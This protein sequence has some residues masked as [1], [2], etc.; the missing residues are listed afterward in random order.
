MNGR[1]PAWLAEWLG[2]PVPTNADSATWQLD[3]RW[4][5]APWATL[6]LVLVAIAW[7]VSLYSRESGSAGRVYRAVL[8]SLRLAAIGL[9][10]VMLAQWALAL[11]LTGPPAVALV[12]DHSASMGIADRYDDTAFA[13]RLNERLIANSLTESTRLNIAKLVLTEGNGRLLG[14]LA[15]RY[16]LATYIAAGNV[17]RLPENSNPADLA[18]DVQTLKTDD[19][20]SQATR[21]GDALVR[22]QDDFR[23]APPAAVILLSDGVVTEGVSL[24]DAA[25]GLRSAGIPLVAVGIGS[26]KPPRDIELSDVLVDDVVFV[27]D[28]VSLQV[29]IKASGLEGQPSKVTLK[30]EGESTPLME[31][32]IVLPAG[33]KTLSVHLTE[34]PTKPGDVTYVVEIAPREDESDTK[35]NSQR[36]SV[37]VRDEKIRVLLAQGYPNYE[38]RFLKL[39]LERDP[40]VQ[41]STY[42]QDADPEYAQQDKTALRSFPVNRNDLFAYDVI[43]IGDLDP[44]LLPGSVWQNVRAFVAEKGGGAALIAGP[45]FLPGRYRDNP[46]VSALLPIKLESISQTDERAAEANRGFPVRPTS[47]GLQSPAMQLGDS[48]NETQQIWSTLAPLFWSLPIGELKP[49]AQVLAEGAAKPVICFQYFGAGRVLFH[50]IDSTW[51]WRNGAEE[52]A[53]ARYWV[54]TIRFLAHGKLGKGRGVQLTSDRREYRR[55]DVAK[56]RVR[57]LDTQ[58]APAGD[59]VV[60]VVDAGGQARRRVTLRRNPAVAG[61]FEGSLANMTDGSYE[62]LMVEP[63]LAE[64]PPALRFSV[65]APPGEFARTEM[66]SDALAAAAETTHGRFYTINDVDQ[67]MANLPAGRRVPI[68]NLPPIS[69]WNRWWL[70]AAFLGCITTE[71]ILRKRKGML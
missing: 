34:R 64:K 23:G 57:F 4:S 70:L 14:E 50:A 52:R 36:R 17:K 26:A 55:G 66:D 7:T 30:R 59:E 43:I 71:W 8:V 22:V 10:L 2:V 61:V 18:R 29:Q 65:V 58:L 38:F 39:L 12:I 35:N 62:V 51:R 69:I 33:G 21:V 48:P 46:D 47:L 15:D 54:Q 45:K 60:V 6:L 24:A 68:E 63:Q 3:S 16:R 41:L 42:L 13:S 9:V 40:T 11:W 27:N 67:L 37:S 31:Q 19:P 56:L 49:A 28:M 25:Q 44:R 5:W 53:F 1:L 32:S 20:A